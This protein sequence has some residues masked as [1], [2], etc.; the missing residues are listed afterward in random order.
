MCTPDSNCGGD[1]LQSCHASGDRIRSLLLVFTPPK[2]YSFSPMVSKGSHQ[3]PKKG[4]HTQPLKVLKVSC[5]SLICSRSTCGK[6]TLI[7]G[8]TLPLPATNYLDFSAAQ[9]RLCFEQ[10]LGARGESKHIGAAAAKCISSISPALS[11]PKWQGAELRR[12]SG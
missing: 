10:L 4:A 8:L 1:I 11:S 5:S 9:C 6:F 2:C 12:Q 7:R 3:D